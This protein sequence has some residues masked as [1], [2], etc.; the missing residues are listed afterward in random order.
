MRT[1]IM[2]HPTYFAAFLFR[3]P[4]LIARA[5]QKS[6]R[7]LLETMTIPKYVPTTKVTTPRLKQAILTPEI[8]L[9][10]VDCRQIDYYPCARKWRTFY[11]KQLH[12]ISPPYPGHDILLPLITSLIFQFSACNSYIYSMGKHQ[13]IKSHNSIDRQPLEL[14]YVRLLIRLQKKR[15]G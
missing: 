13:I 4:E 14:A 10:C 15:N 12:W 5:M 2:G 3:P 9:R 11:T 8:G 6:L 7:A 1:R